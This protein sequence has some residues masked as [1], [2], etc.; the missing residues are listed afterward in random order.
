MR[1]LPLT[2]TVT[3]TLNGG[4]N[5]TLTAGPSFPGE[6]WHPTGT[7]IAA[8]GSVPT[9]GTPATCTVLGPTG[10]QVDST[11]QVTGAA[12]SMITGQDVHPGQVI[13]ATFANC[14]PSSTATLVVTGTRDVP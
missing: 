8:S 14:N 9:G 3:G 10:N 11:Y 12:S 6:V 1:T 2:A 4:G 7:Y 13:S 5:G